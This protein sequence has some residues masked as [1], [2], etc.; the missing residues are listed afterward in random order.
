MSDR[1][2]YPEPQAKKCN[3]RFEGIRHDRHSL[4][5]VA[6]CSMI[7]V[8]LSCAS[9]RLDPN[10]NQALTFDTTTP[11]DAGAAPLAQS[12]P[13]KATASQPSS[14]QDK[15]ITQSSDTGTSA[16]SITC[17]V[18]PPDPKPLHTRD[19]V[20]YE[21]LFNKGQAELQSQ[22]REQTA[23]PRDTARVVGRYAIELWIGCELIDR[24]RFSFPL[25]AA[26]QLRAPSAR[27]P[28]REQPSLTANAQLLT[29]VRVPLEARATR[30][31][32][33]DR[34]TGLRTSLAWPPNLSPKPA[35]NPTKSIVVPN[36]DVPANGS[37]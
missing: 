18:D 33:V 6:V 22:S 23:K 28:L 34:G 25:Q 3:I 32:W 9:A 27:H 29:A 21:F 35:S 5:L 8:T 20:V 37:H 26:E 12:A 17:T 2:N 10:R 14:L 15:T 36:R 24:V 13:V 11:S 19:W 7:G 1:M 30:A 31:E 16:E 4:G